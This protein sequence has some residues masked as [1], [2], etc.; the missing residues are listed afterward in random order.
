VSAVPSGTERGWIRRIVSR[1]GEIR[2]VISGV[3]AAI[4][5]AIIL[6]LVLE[7]GVILLSLAGVEV[8]KYLL[9]SSILSWL[10]HRIYL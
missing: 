3:I 1:Q 7:L 2:P 8:F 10:A 5:S 6:V 9:G 4:L